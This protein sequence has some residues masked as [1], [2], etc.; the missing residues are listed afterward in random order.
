VRSIEKIGI[1]DIGMTAP[2]PCELGRDCRLMVNVR[3]KGPIG[4]FCH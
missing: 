3:L 4:G 2:L 1:S